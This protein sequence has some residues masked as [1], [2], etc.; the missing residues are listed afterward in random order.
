MD[1]SADRG[2]WDAGGVAGGD[3]PQGDWACFGVSVG[4]GGERTARTGLRVGG[5]GVGTFGLG[6]GF[7]RTNRAFHG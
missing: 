7:T 4:G 6:K 5:S 3:G 2:G 1:H